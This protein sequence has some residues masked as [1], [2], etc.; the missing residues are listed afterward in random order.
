M[1]KNLRYYIEKDKI[2]LHTVF[3]MDYIEFKWK[4]LDYNYLHM[5]KCICALEL[6]EYYKL[7]KYL[8]KEEYLELEH[9]IFKIL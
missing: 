8:S 3:P 9:E 7:K 6:S 5:E 4:F 1:N 2:E